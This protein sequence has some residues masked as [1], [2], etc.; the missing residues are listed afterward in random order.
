[1]VQVRKIYNQEKL[2]I[3]YV[4]KIKEQIKL[5]QNQN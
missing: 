1:M 5:A 2:K 4:V 3:N